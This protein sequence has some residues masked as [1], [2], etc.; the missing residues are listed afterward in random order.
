MGA[1]SPART[2]GAAALAAGAGLAWA[3]AEAHLFTLRRVTVPLLPAGQEPLRVLHLSDL[4]LT[5]RQDDKIEWLRSLATLEPHLVVDTGDN[6]AHVDAMPALA[7]ALEPLLHTPGA[8]AMGSNDYHAPVLKN[9]ARYL[10]PDGRRPV[11]RDHPRLPAGDL[12]RL[13]TGAGWVDLNNRRGV[14]VADGRLVSLVGVNDAHLDLDRFP[15]GRHHPD[16]A[17]RLGVTHAPYQ[18]VLDTMAYD[19]VDM[20]LAG[21]THGGQLALPGWGALVTNCDLDAGRAKGLHG[22]PG[23]R[24]DEPGGE[25]SVWLHVS[26]GLG[27]SPFTPVRF[28]CRPEATLLTLVPR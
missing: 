22:W 5:P 25:E 14:A 2:L 24:P 12:A 9:P 13:L 26:A 1:I 8:F 11:E 10:L 17:L 3:L 7:H 20:V 27:T 4:H 23:P 6:W 19:G 15:E 21:H 18:R 16:A 28:A